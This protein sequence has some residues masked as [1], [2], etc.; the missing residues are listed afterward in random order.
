MADDRQ[1]EAVAESRGLVPVEVGERKRSRARGGSRRLRVGEGSSSFPA[2]E[3]SHEAVASAFVDPFYEGAAGWDV[4]VAAWP[5]RV[6]SLEL[7]EHETEVGGGNVLLE[8]EVSRVVRHGAEVREVGGKF[9][10]AARAEWPEEAVPAVV[11]S[12]AILEEAHAGGGCPPFVEDCCGVYLGLWEGLVLE[13]V[14]PDEPSPG[15][16]A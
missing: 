12:S 1:R 13:Y 16:C 9:G 2:V 3:W 15:G 8:S 6:C 14:C 10:R 5:Q 4:K 7:V 11:V